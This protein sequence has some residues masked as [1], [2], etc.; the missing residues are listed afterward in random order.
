MG[1]SFFILFFFFK[2]TYINAACYTTFALF[3]SQ[4]KWQHT[5]IFV[6]TMIPIKVLI[7]Q[8]L[9]HS[10]LIKLTSTFNQAKRKWVYLLK[11]ELIYLDPRAERVICLFIKTTL[12]VRYECC[13]QP[14]NL[15]L[16]QVFSFSSFGR[17]TG[18]T[19]QWGKEL[20]KSR[21]RTNSW[22]CFKCILIAN[23]LMN[24]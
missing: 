11:D 21:W 1:C 5:V 16:T 7:F 10:I 13:S 19:W 15:Q 14:R 17:E 8:H 20:S 4:S 3:K 9:V 24:A 22:S 18:L 12:L 6:V 2:Q 23:R